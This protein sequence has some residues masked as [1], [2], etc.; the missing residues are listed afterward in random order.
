MD[1]EG[2]E[3]FEDDDGDGEG[4]EED[5]GYDKEELRRNVY[6]RGG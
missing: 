6:E 2:E 1:E 5:D 3:E 4:Q